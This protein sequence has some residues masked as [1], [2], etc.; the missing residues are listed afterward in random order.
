MLLL[1]GYHRWNLY[2]SALK[3]ISTSWWMGGLPV[4]PSFGMTTTKSFKI[5]NIFLW[6][7][8]LKWPGIG[9]NE[10]GLRVGKCFTIPLVFKMS[11]N[12]IGDTQGDLPLSW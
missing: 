4:H 9:C 3:I 2:L 7:T 5:K 6:H 11:Y 12:S 10:L 1:V 8:T